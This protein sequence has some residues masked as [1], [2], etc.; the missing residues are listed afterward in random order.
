MVELQQFHPL[1]PPREPAPENAWS[2]DLVITL[3]AFILCAVAGLT[4]SGVPGVLA[5]L[6][7]LP[8]IVRRH[9]PMLMLYGSTAGALMQLPLGDIQFSVVVVPFVIYQV[10]RWIEPPNAARLSVIIGVVG[11]VLG[12]MA[13]TRFGANLQVD[14]PDL[15]V[16]CFTCLVTV[17]TA[18]VIGRRRYEA[19]RSS[20]DRKVAAEVTLRMQLAASEQRARAA[21]VNE[22]NRIARELHDIVAHSLSVI[23][24]QAEGG[25][26]LAAK[27]PELAADVLDTI[28]ETS[29]ESLTEMRRIVG[30][31]RN[32]PERGA[33]DYKP[34][35]GLA[36]LPD[37]VARTT[38]RARLEIRGQ[39][40]VVAQ[41]LGLSVYRVVQEALTN[42]LKHGGPDARATVL[43]DCTHPGTLE[44][45]VLDDGRGSGT[46]SDGQGNGLRGMN[47]RVQLVG[48]RLLARP[49]REGGFEIR[50]TF[51]IAPR[52]SAPETRPV[53]TRGDGIPPR[54]AWATA[55]ATRPRPSP[56][57]ALP[58]GNDRHPGRPYGSGASAPQ[59]DDG[60]GSRQVGPAATR[61]P[62]PEGSYDGH[63][64]GSRPADASARP[65]EPVHPA[66]GTP[67]RDPAGPQSGGPA[68]PRPAPATGTPDRRGSW[69]ADAAGSPGSGQAPAP[70]RPQRPAPAGSSDR[71]APRPR[72]GRSAA[73]EDATALP[74]VAAPAEQRRS[75][76]ERE[77]DVAREAAGAREA[78][79]LPRWRGVSLQPTATEP[80]EQAA[81]PRSRRDRSADETTVAVDV[82][83]TVPLPDPRP[84]DHRSGGSRSGDH[85]SGAHRSGGHR[86]GGHRDDDA[87]PTV[88]LAPELEP[89]QVLPAVPAPRPE[90]GRP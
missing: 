68:G 78:A 58:P 65:W 1:Q 13:W 35:P 30:V 51:P 4:T 82:Q 79:A 38:D 71:H 73:T 85:R 86:S 5:A 53:P 43:L 40:P 60:H 31:L 16:Y 72:D 69:A 74:R 76:G 26:A 64:P 19:V 84:D 12:P 56:S 77:A 20:D 70:V 36:D 81:L 66:L 15:L 21:E 59:R 52:P 54:P 80:P 17:L 48:G 49:R 63:A 42:M 55:P 39:V 8:L 24:V 11:S 47:E 46:T 62:G 3:V 27:K 33:A 87:E 83:P 22:R 9:Y 34:A 10:A 28:A 75:W 45:R 2:R 23:V 32:G 57:P 6:I 88:Q 61:R 37:L 41:T 14:S 89:T 18:Y 90:R 67:R 7:A 50:A 44:L 25:R 29:R